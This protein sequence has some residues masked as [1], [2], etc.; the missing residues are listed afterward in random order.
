MAISRR[1]PRRRAA[2]AIAAVLLAA[3]TIA[4]VIV[5]PRAFVGPAPPPFSTVDP[6]YLDGNDYLRGVN[7]YSLIFAGGGV[8]TADV[9]EPQ[10]SYDFLSGR[11][12][13][14]IRLAVPWQRLQTIPAGGTAADGLEQPIDTEYLDMVAEQVRRAGAA[15]IRTVIDLHNG[16]TYPWGA[17][18]F[19]EGSLRCGDGISE[20]HVTTIWSTI[21]ERFRDDG[22]VLAYDV[23]NEPRWSV[24]VDTYKRFA[25][26]AVDAIRSTGDAHTVWIEGILSDT[27]GRLSAIAPDGPWI[28]D[29][30]G[31][32]MYS[33]HFY[34]DERGPFEPGIVAEQVFDRLREFGDWCERWGVRCSVGEV[35]WPSGGQ[36]GVYSRESAEGWNAFFEQFYSIADEYSFDVTYF[37]A[38]GSSDA[39]TLLAYVASVPGIPS[40]SG[41][42]TAL[43][44]AEVIE[45]HLTR[46]KSG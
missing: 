42:D 5:I 45:R 36:G 38:S 15:G 23:F 37:A 8:A 46:P 10:T 34:A 30:L 35:G 9:G 27:R 11:G 3:L 39:G 2:P 18:E 32:V 1:L 7:V 20:Q 12:V 24:G 33:E 6:D 17:G 21:A 26:V 16:C 28:V 44:Q 19:V 4:A 13:S 41:I 43:S 29:E 22:N 25:Q 14:I 40:T 31:L